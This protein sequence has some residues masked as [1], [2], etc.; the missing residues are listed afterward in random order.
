M[1]PLVLGGS[2]Y[3]RNP[4]NPKT[5]TNGMQWQYI[6]I[7]DILGV[8][9]F[10]TA[11]NS[12]IFNDL[13]LPKLNRNIP[14]RL[15]RYNDSSGIPEFRKALA[16]Y[17]ERYLEIPEIDPEHVGIATGASAV[18]DA[19]CWSVLNDGDMV[20]IPQPYYGMYNVVHDD[21]RW[22]GYRLR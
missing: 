10:G 5:N 11:E 8:I 15:S 3:Q 16:R 20:M 13:I 7:G 19:F 6:D 9:N 17:L 18:M 12:L 22:L 4:Y 14:I 21:D 2:T 1:H